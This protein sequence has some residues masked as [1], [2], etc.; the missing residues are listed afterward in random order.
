VHATDELVVDVTTFDVDWDGDVDNDDVYR[1][2]A[3]SGEE[4]ETV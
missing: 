1:I 3:A 4:C 2:R